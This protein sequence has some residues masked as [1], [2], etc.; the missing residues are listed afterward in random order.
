MEYIFVLHN[1]KNPHFVDFYYG[2]YH[3]LILVYHKFLFVFNSFRK[4]LRSN[5]PHHRDSSNIGIIITRIKAIMVRTKTIRESSICFHIQFILKI[6]NYPLR[7]RN[8]P[9]S[10]RKHYNLMLDYP[11]SRE[12]YKF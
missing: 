10:S 1:N 6:R 3:I 9:T 11:L 12:F 2:L 7:Y 5:E 8:K 4:S